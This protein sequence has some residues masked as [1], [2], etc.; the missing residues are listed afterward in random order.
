M[1]KSTT[2]TPLLLLLILTLSS[3][4]LYSQALGEAL[5]DALRDALNKDSSSHY[6]S[7]SNYSNSGG[8]SP[9]SAAPQGIDPK[10]RNQHTYDVGYRVGQD[11]YHAG[12]DKHFVKHPDLFDRET[13]EPFGR[14]YENGYDRARSEANRRKEQERA[15][16][17]SGHAESS[18]YPSGHYPYSTT[19]KNASPGEQRRHGYEV[20]YRVG[21]DDFNGGH[22]KHYTAHPKLYTKETRHD[23]TLGYEHG[24]DKARAQARSN[25]GHEAGAVRAA[26]GQGKITIKQGDKVLSTIRTAAPNVEQHHFLNGTSQIVVKSRGN[27]G[28]AT[29]QLFDTKTGQLRDKVLAF[30][31]RN[32]EPS[33]AKDMAD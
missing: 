15:R 29:V 18:R 30:A 1:N 2:K 14:G 23:F 10:A 7:S 26:V 12:R 9:Y 28:P 25:Q 6:Q 32:G 13:R 33:W 27:H 4:S 31:I 16:S 11:D 3:G 20:G 21:Q 22:S 19:P 17:H 5:A 24:Y 8:Y